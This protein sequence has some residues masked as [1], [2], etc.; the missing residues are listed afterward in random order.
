[1]AKHS[2]FEMH[3]LHLSKEYLVILL[4]HVMIADMECKPSI[5]SVLPPPRPRIDNNIS[6]S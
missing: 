3:V 5:L 6:L 4:V 1:M 2:M